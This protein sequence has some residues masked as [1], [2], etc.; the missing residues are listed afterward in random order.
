MITPQ[1]VR[2]MAQYNQWQNGRV[3]EAC[4][5]LSEEERLL[6]RGAFWGSIH[7]TLSHI[8]WADGMWMS[9][10]DGWPTPAVG[11]KDSPN[12]F[13][14][15]ASLRDARIDTDARIVAWAARVE[16]PWLDGTLTWFSGILQREVTR[17]VS[18]LVVHFFNHQTHHRGQ[19]HAQ[20]TAAGIDPGDTDLLLMLK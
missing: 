19:V 18:A 6:P 12:A 20:M 9:R 3:L 7:G 4:A 2:T 5:R 17:E 10:F 15:F 8:L 16:A 1:Y 14:D 13:P 11:L